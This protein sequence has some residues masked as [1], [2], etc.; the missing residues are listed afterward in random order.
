MTR[1][2]FLSAQAAVVAFGRTVS[3]K[4]TR[5][6]YR[7]YVSTNTGPL[8]PQKRVLYRRILRDGRTVV[9]DVI[10]TLHPWEVTVPFVVIPTFPPPGASYLGLG[11]TKFRRTGAGST[12]GTAI[13]SLYYQ[14]E[15][16][17]KW[18]VPPQEMY[19]NSEK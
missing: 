5:P 13:T 7:D 10:S 16:G 15:S 11:R 19:E 14:Y 8:Q 6:T 3:A 4:V 12:P 9:Q 1:R 17:P 2:L 18:W